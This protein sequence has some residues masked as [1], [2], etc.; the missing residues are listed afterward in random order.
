MKNTG[1]LTAFICCT[2]IAGLT[3]SKSA[4]AGVS[5]GISYSGGGHG[6]RDYYGYENHG[7]HA[8]KQ[9][10]DDYKGHYYKYEPYR[11]NYRYDNYQHGYRRS[12]LEHRGIY[13]RPRWQNP[14]REVSKYSNDEYGHRHKIG[15]MMCFDRYG[16]GYVVEGSR[17]YIW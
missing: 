8:R 15:G 5:I 4:A 17:Y 11:H 2:I 7:R 10:Q 9:H 16:E 6:Y 13:N 12:Y 3:I 14:C 1:I